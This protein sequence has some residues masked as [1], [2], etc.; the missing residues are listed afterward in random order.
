VTA[1]RFERLADDLTVSAHERAIDRIETMR[2]HGTVSAGWGS[3]TVW[4]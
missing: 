1:R 3:S 2:S 4:W